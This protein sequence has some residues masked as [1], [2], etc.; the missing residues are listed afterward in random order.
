MI[1]RVKHS[2]SSSSSRLVIDRVK[3]S[4]SSNGVTASNMDGNNS[5]GMG[6][7]VLALSSWWS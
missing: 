1:D 5:G 6:R 4:H 3:H 2:H 7:C